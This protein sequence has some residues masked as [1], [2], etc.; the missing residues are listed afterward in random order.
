[1]ATWKEFEDIEAWKRAR[2]L[3][4]KIYELTLTGSLSKD[5]ELVNQSRRSSGSIMD[6]IAEG[7]ER[8]GRKEFIQ[9]LSIAKGSGGELRS[10]SYRMFDRNHINREVFDE[11]HTETTEINK[12][13]NGLI[14]YLKSSEIKGQRYKEKLI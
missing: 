5:Y 3:A 6:N 7:F 9:F 11:L 10:Q 1:M 2:S 14:Q 12:M 8:G 4:Q 13:I